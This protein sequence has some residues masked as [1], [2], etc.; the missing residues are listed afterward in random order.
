VALVGGPDLK[1]VQAPD[2]L[3][4]KLPQPTIEQFVPVVQ[5]QGIGLV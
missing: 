3:R 4:I 1:F 5:I 2:R